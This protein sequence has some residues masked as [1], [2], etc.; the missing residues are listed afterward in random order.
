MK[1]KKLLLLLFAGAIALS[2]LLYGNSLNGEF[3]YDDHFVSDRPE[4]RNYSS[5]LHVWTEPFL[6]QNIFSGLF[7]PAAVFS[8]ALNFIL[9]GESS[10]SFHLIN[11]ILNGIVIFLVFLFVLK[12]FGNHMLAFLAALFFAFLPIHT[13]SVAFIKSRDEILAALFAL[14]SWLLFISATENGSE[15]NLKKM[16]AS[17]MLFLLAVFSKEL[18]II[19]PALFLAVF[20]ATKRP[21]LQLFLKAASSFLITGI[22]YLWFR[23]QVLGSYAFGTDKSYFAINPLGYAD[24]QTRI[25]TSFKI[26]FIYISKTFVPLNLSATYHFNHLTLVHYF[27]NSWQAIA[28][29]VILACLLFWFFWKRTRMT[30]L[31]IGAAAFLIPYAIISKFFF[32]SGDI[33]AERWMYFPS[34]GLSIIAAYPLLLIYRWKKIPAIII[35]GLVLAV[36]SAVIIPRN[37]IWLSDENLFR[38]MIK[39][40]PNSVQGH[41]NLAN[42]YMREG[43]TAEAKKEAEIAFAIDKEYPPLLNT[44]GGIA[45]GDGNYN[46]AETAFLKAIE[47]APHIPVGYINAGRLFY[48]TGQYERAKKMFDPAFRAY[49]RPKTEDVLVYAFTLAKLKQYQTSIDVLIKYLAGDFINPQVKMILAVDYFKLGKMSEARKYFDWDPVMSEAEKIKILRTF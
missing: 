24:F 7:R 12:L 22:F 5:L 3:V 23:F 34:V 28:G 35:F 11:I 17:A 10:A 26:A 16:T 8:F 30:P 18:I 14:W 6:P 4:L 36:Y 27:L 33:L 19:V 37:R 13:E 45:F 46:L 1:D 48:L 29:F 15:L 9:F 47:L 25:W 38:S 49:A 32:K 39:T 2:F 40:A 42:W 43:K 41:S 21:G 20:L 31:G 44:I